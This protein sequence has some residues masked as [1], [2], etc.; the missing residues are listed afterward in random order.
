M[1]PATAV[2]VATV[3]ASLEWSLGE[4]AKGSFSA[5]WV[6]WGAHLGV[7]LLSAGVVG[8]LL[9]RLPGPVVLLGGLLPTAGIAL[10]QL[11]LESRRLQSVTDIGGP[12]HWL[13]I[14]VIALLAL[15]IPSVYGARAIHR[16]SHGERRRVGLL[17]SLVALLL[18]SAVA[19]HLLGSPRR[20]PRGRA[21]TSSPNLLLIS[22]DTLRQDALAVYGGAESA[23]DPWLR[24]ASVLDGWS[25]SPWTQPALRALLRGAAPSGA[26]EA[27]ARAI[28]AS[29]PWLPV[30]LRDAGYLT[31]A[32]VSNP[33]L[34]SEF[35]FARGFHVYDHA[36]EIEILEPVRSSV[37]ARF[38]RRFLP[39]WRELER[40]DRL[41]RTA[42]RWLAGVDDRTP[43][44]T[45]VHLL[46]PHL[47][48]T[49]RGE[50]G[51]AE[52]QAKPAWIDALGSAFVDGSVSDLDGL[53]GDRWTRDEAFVDALRA[54]YASEVDFAAHHAARILRAAREASG[55]RPLVWVL[56]SDHGEEFYEHGGFE[57]GHSLYQEL[58][59]VPLAIG[60]PGTAG[61]PRSMRLQ[62]IGPWFLARHGLPPL[63][64]PGDLL[65]A[66]L[67]G[68]LVG[69]AEA[70][71]GCTAVLSAGGLL[72]GPPQA[73][74]IA[75]DGTSL[76]L[77]GTG[78]AWHSNV[79]ADRL[80]RDLTPAEDGLPSGVIA[81]ALERWRQGRPGGD[82]V[83]ID[84]ELRN[85]LRSLGYLN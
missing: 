31:A 58:L 37:L 10:H 61:L 23:L 20:P 79:C 18:A 60:G 6:L 65:V 21:A 45:W 19:H 76:L 8:A 59:R 32:F 71:A 80:D 44:F 73:R 51:A 72:Y 9:P 34:R 25:P 48:Y 17:L 2:L 15:G 12:R 40:A 24:S 43:W 41:A 47:P 84:G 52:G 83:P 26:G 35:G 56:T 64:A 68:G 38:W 46:D 50:A 53:R 67:R 22:V 5:L 70:P 16:A 81:V 1:L 28:P 49:L 74:W 54:V 13:S 75:A 11:A 85:H 77:D 63:A 62:D 55:R 82:V 14:S 3:P 30:A 69:S 39:K 42:T 57:H 27:R 4:P 78:G 29:D 7:S 36:A 33:Y 66:E